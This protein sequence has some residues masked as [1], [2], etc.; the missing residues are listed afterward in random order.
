MRKKL[1]ALAVAVGAILSGLVLN[2]GTAHADGLTTVGYYTDYL[3]HLGS[4]A[5]GRVQFEAW[6]VQYRDNNGVVIGTVGRT[7]LTDITGGVQAVQVNA[8][9][10]RWRNNG[11]TIQRNGVAQHQTTPGT[12]LGTCSDTNDSIGDGAHY[13]ANTHGNSSFSGILGLD[14]NVSVRWADNSLGTYPL[15]SLDAVWY[16]CFGTNTQT[17]CGSYA[18]TI[19]T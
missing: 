13:W 2:T 12:Q 7:C 15:G 8:S 18:L 9:A 5:N 11:N 1:A 14:S 10:I 6:I 19:G 16:G 3:D 17:P 4:Q